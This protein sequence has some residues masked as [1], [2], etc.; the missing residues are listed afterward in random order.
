MERSD[1]R[2]VRS[3][4]GSL[5][6]SSR[7]KNPD[8]ENELEFPLAEAKIEVWWTFP[9]IQG[10]YNVQWRW[11]RPWLQMEELN[12]SLRMVAKIPASKK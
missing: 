5:N 1:M 12:A 9:E 2:A 11:L 3:A 7:H 6:M 10:A 4:S 8:S